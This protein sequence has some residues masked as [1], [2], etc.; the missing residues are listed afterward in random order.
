M[1]TAPLVALPTGAVLESYLSK[2][3]P[4][5]LLRLGA[6]IILSHS[7]LAAPALELGFF[8]H[9]GARVARIPPNA[10]STKSLTVNNSVYD[11]L[12]CV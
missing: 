10:N 2:P 8:C 3:T 7:R 9:P 4:S 6:Q 12:I 11:V 5:Q 1:D